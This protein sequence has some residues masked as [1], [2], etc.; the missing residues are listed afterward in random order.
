MRRLLLVAALVSFAGL[1]GAANLFDEPGNGI[2]IDNAAYYALGRK[3]FRL[4]TDAKGNIEISPADQ[5][6]N[7]IYRN[8]EARLP[9]R[10]GCDEWFAADLVREPNGNITIG[11]GRCRVTLRPMIII[12]HLGR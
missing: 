5:P 1:A 3:V 12:R 4:V 8:G 10:K 7:P 11:A 2:P 9:G 6:A